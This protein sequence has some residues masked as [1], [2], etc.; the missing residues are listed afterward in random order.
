[1]SLKE[2]ILSDFKEAFKAGDTS[3]K[4]TLSLIKAAIQNKE[5]ESHKKE[6][7]LSD[8]EVIG[9]LSSEAKKRKDAIVEYEKAQR[10][11][12]AQIEKTE[13]SIIETY[14]PA[15]MSREEVSK[16]LSVVISETGA[17]SKQ[18]MG[19]IMGAAM[20]RLK[21]KADGNLVK[22]ELEKLLN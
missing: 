21:G 1:M 13:L 19:K 9:V 4:E 3:K 18:D 16:E 5:I 17:T 2:K 8:E 15:Q 11:E 6:E 14:L 22:E 12:Q 20:A 7:G 10:G